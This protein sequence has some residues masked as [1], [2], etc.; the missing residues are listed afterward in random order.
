MERPVRLHN[1]SAPA[2]AKPRPRRSNPS[3]SELQEG[4][5][6]G[7]VMIG[8]GFLAGTVVAAKDRLISSWGLSPRMA[9]FAQAM[10]VAVGA[11]ALVWATRQKWARD[12]RTEILVGG[13]ALL[14]PIAVDAARS[15]RSG[16]AGGE[17]TAGYGSTITAIG[18][19]DNYAGLLV[20]DTRRSPAMAGVATN[21]I[22]L[23]A[24]RPRAMY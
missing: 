11:W 15:F 3:R 12:M 9:A 18:R 13:T 16:T 22:D 24:T 19:R 4:I 17:T 5:T 2:K 1:P 23:G 10:M 21:M 7:A 6:L 14:T 20:D 8:G